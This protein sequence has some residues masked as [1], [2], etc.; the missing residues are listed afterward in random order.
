MKTKILFVNYCLALGGAEKLLYEV[1]KFVSSRN[2]ELTVIIPNN[3]EEEYYDDIL[4][5]HKV[6][7]V[8][9]H[10]GSIK[11][12]LKKKHLKSIYWYFKL[13][14]GLQNFKTLHIFNLTI[15]NRYIRYFPHPQRYFWH[16]TNNIQYPNNRYTFDKNI[17]D[18]K[19]D[20]IVYINQYQN[21]EIE[22]E[23]GYIKLKKINFKLFLN[24]VNS[25]F[26][27]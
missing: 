25:S 4:K 17:F 11:Q 26:E 8:R 16:I 10:L 23:Y 1:V 22:E 20:T 13:R 21:N 24:E 14:F 27:N 15:V 18:N 6:K 19:D 2:C 5:K 9:I 3:L 7:V 12:V